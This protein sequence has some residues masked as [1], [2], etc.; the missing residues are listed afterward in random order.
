MQL[1]IIKT[2][3]LTVPKGKVE[4]R[5]RLLGKK[6]KDVEKALVK[7]AEKYGMVGQWNLLRDSGTGV[8]G[9][10]EIKYS[11]VNITE[12]VDTIDLVPTLEELMK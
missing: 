3:D 9:G 11:I 10:K 2:K 4:T 6:R 1:V 8:A 5:I 12:G 7:Y